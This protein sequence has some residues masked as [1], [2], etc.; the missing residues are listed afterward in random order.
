MTTVLGIALAYFGMTPLQRWLNRA[1]LLLL[2]LGAV[3]GVFADTVNEAKGVF[4]ACL[5]GVMLIVL[6][7]AL[8]GGIALRMASRPSYAHLRPHGRIKILL[9]T[10]L[11]MTMIVLLLALPTLAANA[12]MMARNLQPS[13]RFGEGI[14]VLAI[15][16]PLAAMTWIILFATS[17]TMLGALAF[18]LVV[19][20]A[21]KLVYLLNDYPRLVAILLVTTGPAAWLLFS[22][23]YMRAGRIQQP[24][25]PFSTP[26][27]EHAPFQWLFGGERAQNPATTPEV[28][29]FHYLLGVG[30]YWIFLMSGFWIALLFLLMQVIMPR[31]PEASEGL[32]LVMLPFLTFNSAVMGYSTARRA[33]LLWLRTGADRAG[34]FRLAE[35]LGLCASMLTWGFVGGAVL[36]Y[37]LVMN[38]QNAARLVLYVASQGAAA[39]CMYYG[40]FALVKDWSAGDKAVVLLLL[41]LFVLQLTVFGVRQ[42]STPLQSW[43][44]LL[45]IASGLAIALRWFGQ[46]QW[47]TVDWQRIRPVRFDLKGST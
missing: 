27:N 44:A 35:K 21:M 11:A 24:K 12:V 7:P 5:F 2:A 29:T 20:G 43:T 23:W 17:R 45:L 36:L 1:G 38:P 22:L 13:N 30:S 40:G 33:R 37:A 41:A 19:M 10:T 46:R 6:V 26:G 28:A 39:I 8:G 4:M 32:L 9:G 47:R 14:A 34:L 25:A 18:P 31:A 42:V 16:W 15:M 3:L